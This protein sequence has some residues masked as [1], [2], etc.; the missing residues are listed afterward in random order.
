M[1]GGRPDGEPVEGLSTL[2]RFMPYIMKGRNEAAVYFEQRLMVA[3]TLAFIEDFNANVS[4][5]RERI[6]F[7][8]VVLAAA[9]RILSERS[10]LNR[11]VVGRRVYQRRDIALSFAVKKRFE[12]TGLLTTVKMKLKPF[13]GLDEVGR[14]MQEAIGAGRGQ[15]Q[16]TSEKEMGVLGWLPRS[17]LMGVMGLQRLL[18]HFGLL[19]GSMLEPDPLYASMF[20]ANLGSVGLDAPFHHLYEYGTVP[21]FVAIG[22]IK[23]APVVDGNGD[24]VAAQVVDVRYTLDE[25]IADGFYCARS[26]ERFRQLVEAPELLLASDD[27]GS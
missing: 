5:E 6:T 22:R 24:V 25:R 12:D 19:P 8:Q 18:D 23:K 17:A 13:D 9:V 26:L 4:N 16:T 20:L 1:F 27:A 7:F 2:R 21:I 11:F 14:Q 15:A 10:A 3:G